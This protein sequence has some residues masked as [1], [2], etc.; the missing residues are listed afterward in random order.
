M[1]TG[2]RRTNFAP[3]PALVL[4]IALVLAGS[5]SAHFLSAFNIS[6]VLTQVTPLLLVAAGETFVVATGG[7]DLSVGSIVSLASV[8]SAVTFTSAGT[9]PAVLITVAAA[10]VAGAVNG[11]LVGRGLEPFLVTLA[12]SSVIQGIAFSVLASPGG[13]V[14]TAVGSLAGFFGN[15]TVPV[16][17]P[18]IT[19]AVVGAGLLIRRARVGL[20]MLAVGSNAHVARLCSVNVSRT[21]IY[22]YGLSGLLAGLAGLVVNAQTLNGNPLAG[23]NYTL[24]AIAAVVLGGSV[25]TGGRVTMVGSALGAIAL[26]LLSDLLNFVH[27]STFYQNIV[28]GIVVIVAVVLPLSIVRGARRARS[29]AD[30]REILRPPDPA[31]PVST[32]SRAAP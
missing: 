7:I 5:R 32:A 18:E 19:L 4:V 2:L 8:V 28:Q 31:I 6:N 11:V 15:G 22:A 10:T 24:D 9:I 3:V 17:L 26:G 1:L 16:I 23:S 30:A 29:M 21:R 27:I 12:S 14:P 13:S 25:L 20:D